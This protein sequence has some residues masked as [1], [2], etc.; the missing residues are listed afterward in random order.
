M[1]FCFIWIPGPG[2]GWGMG[3]PNS[4]SMHYAGHSPFQAL[5]LAQGLS[6]FCSVPHRV[7]SVSVLSPGFYRCPWLGDPGSG[8]PWSPWYLGVRLCYPVFNS[9]PINQEVQNHKWFP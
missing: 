6:G 2:R 5:L 9:A 8:C 3:S 1:L 4:P 7:G